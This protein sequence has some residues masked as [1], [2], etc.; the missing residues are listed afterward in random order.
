[1]FR[2]DFKNLEQQNEEA[3]EENSSDLSNE[4]SCDEC[5]GEECVENTKNVGDESKTVEEMRKEIYFLKE[6][7]KSEQSYIAQKG[8]EKREDVSNKTSR[9]GTKFNFNFDHLSVVSEAEETSEL[10][11][12][13]TPLNDFLHNVDMLSPL[14]YLQKLSPPLSHF[15]TIY[16]KIND[17]TKG[18]YTNFNC[19]QR[20]IN[21]IYLLKD[22]NHVTSSDNNMNINELVVE[23][24]EIKPKHFFSP[25]RKKVQPDVLISTAVQKQTF[26]SGEKSNSVNLCTEEPP[27]TS[28]TSFQ[29]MN[30]L[31]QQLLTITYNNFIKR[32]VEI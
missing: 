5:C 10:S 12:L 20:T 25:I 31:F 27:P 7:D 22:Q 29:V 4:C 6:S 2:N 16:D 13:S 21:I 28:S 26:F 11:N 17:D 30:Y 19:N 15:E 8:Q 14:S 24:I 3:N 23:K 18:T 32:P 1:M 9:S